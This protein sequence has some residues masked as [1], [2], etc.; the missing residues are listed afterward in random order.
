MNLVGA[1]GRLFFEFP[2]TPGKTRKKIKKKREFLRKT[3]FRL[4]RLFYMVVIQKLITLNTWKFHQMFMLVLSIYIQIFTK[5]VE[6]A[7]NCN[8]NYYILNEVMNVY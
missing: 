6:N 2:N 8:L 5:S 4:N 3:S 7:K 1:L